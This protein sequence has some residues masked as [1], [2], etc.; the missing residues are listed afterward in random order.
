MF[1]GTLA[2]SV[3]DLTVNDAVLRTYRCVMWLS[4]AYPIVCSQLL[5]SNFYLGTMKIAM[6]TVNGV[7]V[8]QWLGDCKKWH[9]HY[10]LAVF[11]KFN[12]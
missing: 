1:R 6:E 10:L 9:C 12:I 11:V 3:L 8:L 7:C 2:G 5:W 4:V